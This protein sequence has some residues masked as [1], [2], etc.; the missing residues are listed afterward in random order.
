MERREITA[1]SELRDVAESVMQ[2][3]STQKDANAASVVALYGDLGAGKTAMVK[4]LALELGIVED[5]TSPTFVIL[6]NY[7]VPQDAQTAKPFARLA[8]I[9]AY[10]IEDKDELRPLHFSN[11]L[12][13]KDTIVCIEWADRIEELLPPHTVRV[14][15]EIVQEKRSITIE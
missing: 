15:L 7:L 9:D 12:E 14:R 10:R 6:K 3:A 1:E 13:Q 8:H 2:R 11:L 4:A 5:V